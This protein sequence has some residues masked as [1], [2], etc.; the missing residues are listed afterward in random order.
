M[1]EEIMTVTGP[2][3]PGELGFT[4]PHEHVFFDTWTGGGTGG[5]Q[6]IDPVLEW[7]IMVAELEAYRRGGGATLIDLTLREIG[8]NPAALRRIAEST[9]VN[10]VMGCGWYIDP[11]HPDY[12]NYRSADEMASEL[13]DEIE[14]GV[15]D[16]G[17][18]PGIIGEIGCAAE[19][20]TAREERAFRAAARA[21]LQ[22]GLAISTHTPVRT[23]GREV[24]AILTQEGVPPDR[25]I[26]GHADTYPVLD[27]LMDL[28]ATGCYIEFDCIGWIYNAPVDMLPCTPDQL[29]A[30]T[31][32]LVQ[33]GHADRL[34]LSQDVCHRSLFR[35]FGGDGFTCVSER[36]LPLLREKGVDEESITMITIENAPRV[37]AGS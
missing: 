20:P 10:I 33:R 32:E 27:Y 16:T 17:V 1:A 8:R 18:R 15:D 28:L 7:D 4:L 21:H 23:S 29:A 31:V 25:V 14:N 19:Y 13:V 37:L 30:L 11:F 26:I 2:V 35:H 34:L 9:G 24:L 3:A 36:F 12:T 6:L 5:G 22:T